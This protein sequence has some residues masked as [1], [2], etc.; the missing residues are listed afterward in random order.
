[1]QDPMH[2]P[3]RV[4]RS[5]VGL[6][7]P[8]HE[9]LVARIRQPRDAEYGLVLRREDFAVGPVPL[10]LAVLRVVEDRWPPVLSGEH[11]DGAVEGA[12]GAGWMGGGSRCQWMRS[13]L[14]TWSQWFWQH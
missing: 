6:P 14:I 9:V 1:M 10:L 12:E 4:V 2:T 3:V 8:G 7:R 13:L 11:G 5:V